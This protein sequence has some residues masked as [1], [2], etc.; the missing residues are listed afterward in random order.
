M[1]AQESVSLLNKALFKYISTSKG[2]IK[3]ATA[4]GSYISMRCSIH[5]LLPCIEHIKT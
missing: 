1:N 4:W 2:R 5:C 3:M